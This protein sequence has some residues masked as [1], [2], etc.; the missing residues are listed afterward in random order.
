MNI[1][2]ILLALALVPSIVYATE[3]DLLVKQDGESLKVYNLEF[4]SGN[5]VFFTL[6]DDADASIQKLATDQILIVKKADG[7]TWTPGQSSEAAKSANVKPK[8]K[9]NPG[10][11]DPVTFTATPGS[12]SDPKKETFFAQG[13][14]L[15]Q[16]NFRI[17][18]EANQTL[19][20]A[21]MPKG[22]KYEEPKYVIP[23]YVQIGDKTYSVVQIDK[24]AF[25]NLSGFLYS[26]KIKEIVFPST[27]KIIEDWSFYGNG[28]L[29]NIILPDGLE[30]IGVCAFFGCLTRSD[31]CGEIYI[32]ES[33][34]HIGGDAFKAVSLSQ[35]FRGFSQANFTSLPGFVNENNCKDFG[36]DEEAVKNYERKYLYSNPD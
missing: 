25:K 31:G 13:E 23:E 7:T 20:V 19:A 3:P 9:T 1:R 5:S 16:I 18:D 24:N 30:T 10:L 32:P 22:Y 11:H 14:N 29:E 35:S 2:S 36:I 27:L 26:N 34:K 33:V 4:G 8:K 28:G 17:L 21:K 12:Y 15:P 6:S